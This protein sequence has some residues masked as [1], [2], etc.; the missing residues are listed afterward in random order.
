LITTTFQNFS[1]TSVRKF[2]SVV[3]VCR[4]EIERILLCGLKD[5]VVGNMDS[6]LFTSQGS[7]TMK[8]ISEVIGNIVEAGIYTKFKKRRVHSVKLA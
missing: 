4:D 3:A 6:F 5:G 2:W 8:Y 1:T 7:L